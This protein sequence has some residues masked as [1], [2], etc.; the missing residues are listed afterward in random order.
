MQMKMRYYCVPIQMINIKIK[1]KQI[2][3]IASKDVEYRN[4][5]PLLVRMQNGTATSEASIVVSYN[6]K[7]SLTTQASNH[8]L[9]IHN[10]LGN[11]CPYK[12][13]PTNVYRI[14]A[15]NLQKLEATKISFTRWMGK[16]TVVCSNNGI[17]L[18]D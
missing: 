7:H 1:K 14:N 4:S 9:G 11:S 5:Y 6:M 3:P 18:R 2:I 16:P 10:W 8:M 12:N 17:L 15:N 13:L